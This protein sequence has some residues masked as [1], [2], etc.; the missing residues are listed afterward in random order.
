MMPCKRPAPPEVLTSERVDE[1]TARFNKP[2]DQGALPEFR[3]PTVD[4]Q[5]LNKHL[6]PALRSMTVDHCAYCDAWPAE[7]L[8]ESI[9]HFRPKSKFRELAFTWSNLF[10]ACPACQ[11]AKSDDWDERALCPTEHDYSFDRYFEFRVDT[12]AIVPRADAS[13]VD[14]ERAEFSIEFFGLNRPG[15]R[16]ARL[17]RLQ[18]RGLYARFADLPS[19]DRPYRFLG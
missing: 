12:G 15:R 4:G 9:D 14:Q 16:R 5:T 18:M 13:K 6:L 7:E 10:P 2:N 17:E 3:W 1:W 8:A 19:E 11:K